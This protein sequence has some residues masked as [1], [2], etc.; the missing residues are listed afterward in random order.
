MMTKRQARIFFYVCI[1]GF[2][3]IFLAMTVHTH[4]KFPELTNSDAITAEVRA[5]DRVW[6]RNNCINC[7]TLFGEG[8]YFAPD[9][10]KITQQRGAPYLKAFL[11]DPSQFYSEERHRRLMP[12]PNLTDEEIDHLIAFLD[13]VS[14]VDNQGWP[15][16][17]ILVSGGAFPGTA[18]M[19]AADAPPTDLGA[20]AA[21]GQEVFRDPTAFCFTC[22]SVAPGVN[23][24]GPSLAGAGKRA[25][26]IV[27][28]PTYE[29]SATDAAGFLRE[30]I[31]EPSAH[32]TPG[33]IYSANGVSFMP[34][35]YE[36]RLSTEQIDQLVEYLLSLN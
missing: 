32:L 10:T 9:L 2:S 24:A 18:E 29:G 26:E 34:G 14:N 22:H 12:N 3:A 25:A 35:D 16:R 33:P 15:P 30:S 17:P 28:D 1:L 36:Q 21:K 5:G 20:P 4:T 27:N 7:H 8:A 11:Q 31:V 13:W 19:V 6:H 23:L